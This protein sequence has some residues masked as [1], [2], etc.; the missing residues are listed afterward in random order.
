[1]N[2]CEVKTS[3]EGF[4]SFCFVSFLFLFLNRGIPQNL[5]N[6]VTSRIAFFP[7]YVSGTPRCH[8]LPDPNER[9]GVDL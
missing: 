2:S 6:C 4:G 8:L 7:S 9:D 1:M 3:M 5:L